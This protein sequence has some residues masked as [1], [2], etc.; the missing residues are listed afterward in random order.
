MEGSQPVDSRK[1]G[2]NPFSLKKGN[3]KRGGKK[4][5]HVSDHSYLFIRF[6]W[7]DMVG[8]KKTEFLVLH[9][10]IYL[11]SQSLYRLITDSYR[12]AL[13]N[14]EIDIS[15]FSYHFQPA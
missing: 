3:V 15:M 14:D 13:L 11:S 6:S 2:W 7:K 10:G 8:G 12:S 4:A 9:V 5:S 1:K